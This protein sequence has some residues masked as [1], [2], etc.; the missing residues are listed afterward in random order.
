M[1][2]GQLQEAAECCRH[3]LMLNPRLVSHL[4][5][6]YSYMSNAQKKM[7]YTWNMYLSKYEKFALH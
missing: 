6:L 5:G 2:K 4:V 1:R 3:A 7:M